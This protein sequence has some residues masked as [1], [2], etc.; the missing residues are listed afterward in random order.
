MRKV[1][2]ILRAELCGVKKFWKTK[3][4]KKSSNSGK[5]RKDTHKQKLKK[6]PDLPEI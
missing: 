4:E 1:Q 6:N 2:M 5:A 3:E